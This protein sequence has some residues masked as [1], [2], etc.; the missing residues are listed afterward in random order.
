LSAALARSLQGLLFEVN[1][2]D[3]L[4]YLAA[5]LV[6]GSVALAAAAAPAWRATRVDPVTV[7]RG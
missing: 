3:A 7:L 1:P 2:S 4:S 5:A 6:L